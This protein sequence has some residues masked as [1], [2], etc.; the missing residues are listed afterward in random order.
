MSTEPNSDNLKQATLSMSPKLPLHMTPPGTGGQSPECDPR[1]RLGPWAP[2]SLGDASNLTHQQSAEE[3]SAV[4][5]RH[6]SGPPATVSHG[7]GARSLTAHSPRQ[8]KGRGGWEFPEGQG[9]RLPPRTQGSPRRR[10]ELEKWA[11]SRVGR[12]P[13][14][15]C[16]R[17]SVPPYLEPCSEFCFRLPH[18]LNWV[19]SEILTCLS[20]CQIKHDNR[21]PSGGAVLFGERVIKVL[22]QFTCYFSLHII[23]LGGII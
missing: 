20:N 9:P 17:R 2:D 23:L 4:R 7:D 6:G 21:H 18:S 8:Q 13:D 22:L 16:C 11:P 14:S 10:E 1:P 15:V 19:K 3:G 12:C 5:G